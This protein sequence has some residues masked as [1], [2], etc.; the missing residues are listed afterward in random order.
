MQGGQVVTTAGL[1][2]HH[3]RSV[4]RGGGVVVWCSCVVLV[5]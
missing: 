4:V 1:E 5:R 2:L 3:N